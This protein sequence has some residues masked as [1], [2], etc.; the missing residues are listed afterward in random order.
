MRK[1]L[2]FCLSA[3]NLCLVF[4]MS[5]IVFYNIKLPDK[6]YVSDKQSIYISNYIQVSSSKNESQYVLSYNDI[7]D[8]SEYFDLK[9][10]GIIPIKTVSVNQITEPMLIPCGNPFGIKLLTDGV[11]VVETSS[12]QTANGYISPAVNAGIKTGDVISKINEQQVKSNSDIEKIVKS[13]NG[14]C[15]KISFQRN[16]S[17]M[18]VFLKP[19]KSSEDNCYRAG[20]WVRDSSAGIGTLTFYNPQSG[21]FAGLGHPVCDVDTGKIMPL[22]SGEVCDVYINGVKKGRQGFP[23]E[24]M[25]TFITTFPVGT[26]DIN[27]CNGLY[28]TLNNSPSSDEAIPLGLRQEIKT[29]KAYILSTINGSQPSKYEIKIEKID[30]N[31]SNGKNMVI[32]VTD[33]DLLS[34]AGGIVQGMS[35]SPIIQD[36]KIIGAVTHV[37]VNNPHKGYAIFADTMYESS[38]L[39]NE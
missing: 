38:L 7:V 18:S 2:R 24:L 13:C 39:V 12:F 28:G 36:G 14:K 1:I 5:L 33:T 26:L 3:L 11:I 35:G 31:N 8:K 37:F 27:C 10:G 15:I 23:G 34:S 9:L 32:E 6:Y 25:G 19:E 16:D 20:M 29:G 30:M 22:S 4:L 17:E 21:V